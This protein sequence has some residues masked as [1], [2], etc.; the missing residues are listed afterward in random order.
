MR[1]WSLP[2]WCCSLTSTVPIDTTLCFLVTGDVGKSLLA[3]ETSDVPYALSASMSPGNTISQLESSWDGPVYLA[4]TFPANVSFCC[5]SLGQTRL[6]IKSI[7]KWNK[8]PAVQNQ[9][10]EVAVQLLSRSLM[11]HPAWFPNPSIKERN[12][13]CMYVVPRIAQN[14]FIRLTSNSAMTERR[15]NISPWLFI[16]F[17]ALLY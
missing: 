6:K 5:K 16:T 10:G 7:K 3:V 8:M 1:L 2:N 14:P 4:A 13:I 15:K 11:L 9:G 17:A 12:L